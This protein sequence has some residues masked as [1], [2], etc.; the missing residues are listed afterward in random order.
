MIEINSIKE[1]IKEMLKVSH[2]MLS[3]TFDGFIKHDAKILSGVL[4]EEEVL[5]QM[6]RSLVTSLVEISKTSVSEGEKEIILKLLDLIGDI[7]MIGDYCKDMIERIEIKIQEKLL[8][9]EEAVSDY[10]HL[11][12]F[13][14]SSLSDLVK[15]IEMKDY[16]FTKRV[17]RDEEHVDE[18]VDRYRKG[19]VQRLIN[20]ICEPRSG[21]MFLN[22]L[23][24]TASIYHHTKKIAQVISELN[25]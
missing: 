11:Y 21:N 13:V 20:G 9:S 8:F 22:L 3:A 6:E 25:L 10:K 17:I 7:E 16:N 2:H 12:A 15:A 1:E 5:N 18:L 19:H 23:D 4:N 14:E 24:F